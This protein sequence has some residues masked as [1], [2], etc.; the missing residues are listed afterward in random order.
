LPA[1][2]LVVAAMG[3]A[4]CQEVPP[5]PQPADL[6]IRSAK[7]A[8][9]DTQNPRAQ[10][11]AVRGDRIVAVGI[12]SEIEPFIEDGKTLVIDAGGRFVVPGFNDAHNHFRGLDLDYVDLRYVADPA[13]VARRVEARVDGAK[14]GELIRGGRWDHELFPD[15]RW[16]TKELLDPVSPDNPVVLSRVDGHSVLVNS[17]VLRQSGITRDTPEPPGGQIVRD[18]VTG[19]PTGIFKEAARRLLDTSGV[20]VEKTPEEEEARRLESWKKA[21]EMA[22]RLGV[23]SLQLAGSDLEVYEMFDLFRTQG[24]LTLRVSLNGELPENEE[25]L[26]QY[27]KMIDRYP[28]EDDWIRFGYLKGYIDGTL[29]SATALLFE[30]FTDEPDKTGLPQMSYEELEQ[31]VVAA[32]RRGFQ[33][34]I[35]AIGDRANHWVLNAYEKA[36]EVNPPRERRHRIEHASILRLDDIPRFAELDVIASTQAVF[37]ST[38]NFYAEKRLGRERSKG[39]YAWRRLLDE[40]AHVAFSTD[41]PVEPL[42]PREGLYAAVTRKNRKGMPESG[43]FP[44]QRLELE[45]AIR[46]YTLEPAYAEFME[47]RK[48]MLRAGYLAD[49]VIFDRDLTNIPPEEI[50]SAQVDYTIVGGRIVFQSK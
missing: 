2:L 1:F 11:L 6:V 27:M 26:N 15:S 45:E 10:A 33:I 38:D 7:I 46:L 37:V 5:A 17:Y 28:R 3:I 35:H 30:P 43:W 36:I 47:D 44:D 18:P 49:I 12:D 19:D 29:S 14:S 42:D 21:F 48:G 41:Y 13:E 50:L 4:S 22:S 24:R 34:G 25:D 40:G 39:V 23:T 32:D 9:I 31:R 8:T 20:E 16:P